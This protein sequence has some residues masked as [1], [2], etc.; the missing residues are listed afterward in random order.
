MLANLRTDQ[1]PALPVGE[2]LETTRFCR[3]GRSRDSNSLA[4]RGYRTSAA[5]AGRKRVAEDVPNLSL[6]H[7]CVRGWLPRRR[8]GEGHFDRRCTGLFGFLRSAATLRVHQ[9]ASRGIGGVRADAWKQVRGLEQWPRRREHPACCVIGPLHRA[10]LCL[11]QSNIVRWRAGEERAV[12]SVNQSQAMQGCRQ[13][14]LRDAPIALP[15]MWF[16]VAASSSMG[17]ATSRSHPRQ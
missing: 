10:R 13:P 15:L 6:R 2:V 14:P 17:R 3:I 12:A 4:D 1:P 11:T 16:R 7:S 5:A 8:Q 9:A